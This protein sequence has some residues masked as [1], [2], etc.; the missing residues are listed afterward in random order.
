MVQIPLY[1]RKQAFVASCIYL[2]QALC[3]YIAGWPSNVIIKLQDP[4][5]TPLPEVLDDSEAF[6]IGTLSFVG[7]VSCGVAGYLSNLK[8]R[9]PCLLL[10][11]MLCSIG[12]LLKALA[13][14]LAMIYVGRCF[15]SLGVGIIFVLNLVYLAEISSTNIRGIFL[16]GTGVSNSFGMLIGYI[17]GGF[18]SYAVTA[19][20][21]FGL[22]VGFC[23]TLFIIPETPYFYLLK[24]EED[25]ARDVLISLGREDD[26]KEI[27]ST[28]L[29]E[30]VGML[31]GWTEIFS[32]KSNRKAVTI[33]VTLMTLQQM[34][35]VMVV[36]L[37]ATSIFELVNSSLESHIS[38]I[39]IGVTQLC[40]S[41]ITPIFIERSGRRILLLL[42]TAVCS[43]CLILLGLYFYL[44]HIDHPSTES[45][46]WLP[47]VTLIIYLM[48]Y[49]F[50][51]GI[52]PGTFNG[53]MFD[54]KVRGPGALFSTSVSWMV[55][56]AV[57]F[58]YNIM[59]ENWGSYT[60][61]WIYAAM[62]AIACLFTAVYV[63]ETKGKSLEEIKEMLSK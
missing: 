25:I 27:L 18:T 57:S 5:Q 43:L 34:S 61:F 51:F 8:G 38:T 1:V 10:G 16:V 31:E 52:I 12:F 46:Q 20:F 3:G 39:I 40:A 41:C 32:V 36:L 23:A 9:V 56:L 49:N 28:K 54:T 33:T 4:E 6:L 11:T 29:P 14:N 7:V 24:H 48:S 2:G 13:G 26:V 45:I 22:A 59:V 60:T 30:P 50:G 21:G 44:A 19:W 35:G 47:L 15:A 58:T 17:V 53:E 42:T 62:S 55:G 63:P 37:F